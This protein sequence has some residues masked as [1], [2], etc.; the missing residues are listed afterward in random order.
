MDKELKNTQVRLNILS[1]VLVEVL[2]IFKDH[3]PN[4][5]NDQIGELLT[6][7]D[8][9]DDLYPMAQDDELVDELADEQTD[10]KVH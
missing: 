10:N 7:W 1:N 3:L 6:T 9:L 4:H 2:I 8:K 5:I